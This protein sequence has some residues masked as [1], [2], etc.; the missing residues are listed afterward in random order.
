MLL[1]VAQINLMSVQLI[2][3]IAIHVFKG[4]GEFQGK[5]ASLTEMTNWKLQVHNLQNYSIPQK[6]LF[7]NRSKTSQKYEALAH[8]IMK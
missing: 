7:V 2:T 3:D 5:K 4:F 6:N 1:K 8:N